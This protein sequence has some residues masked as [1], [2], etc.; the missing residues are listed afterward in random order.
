MGLTFEFDRKTILGQGA[1]GPVFAGEWNNVTVAV[2]RIQLHDLL[3][4]REES[5]MKDLNHRNVVKLYAVEED[6]NFK[7][8]N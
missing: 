3:S 4:D 1:Y 6:E 7:S 8:L 2:K 5:T